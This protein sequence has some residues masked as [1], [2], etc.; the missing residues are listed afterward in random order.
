MKERYIKNVGNL[1]LTDFRSVFGNYG[2]LS[3]ARFQKQVGGRLRYLLT[4]KMDVINCNKSCVRRRYMFF[5]AAMER[6]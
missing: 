4:K 6:N 1:H 2:F 3:G 5:C